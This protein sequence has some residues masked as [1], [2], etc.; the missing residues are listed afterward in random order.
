[1]KKNLPVTQVEVPFTKG[2]YIVSKTDLKGCITYANETFI[3]LSGFSR[4]E[5]YGQSHNLVR[6]PDM[7]PAAFADL[8]ATVK[9]GRPW[10]GI[11]K[12]RCKNGDHYW[13]DALVV[14]VRKDGQTLGYMSVRTEPSRAQIQGAE[15][16]YQRLNAGA[17]TLP[18]PGFWRRLSLRGKMAGLTLFVMAAQALTGVA[19]WFG[20]GMGFSADSIVTLVQ[21]LNLAGLIAGGIQIGLQQGIFRAID[22]TNASLDRVAQG[23]LSE[24][25]WH[26]RLDEVGK[27]QDSLLATQAHLKVMLAEIAEAAQRVNANTRELNAEMTSVSRQSESQ[28]ESVGRIAA[29]MEEMSAAVDQVSTDAKQ[30]AEAVGATRSHIDGVGRRMRQGREASRAVVGAVETASA[31]MATLFQSLN[32]IGVVTQAIQEIADQTNLIALN[33]AIEAARAGEAGRG[34]AVVAD[35]VR[36]LA[37]RTRQQTSEIAG[38]VQEIHRVTETAV[39]NIESA[40]N[41]VGYN[42]AAMGETEADLAEVVRDGESIDEM[43]GHIAEATI[44]Q[45]QASQEVTANISEIAAL[46]EENAA[47]IAD[48]ENNVSQLL[49]TATELD[50]L[51]GYFRFRPKA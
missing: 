20:E 11:V 30:T 4:E 16:L 12:N 43:A 26:E 50:R 32:R 31:T 37:E 36:K 5:L 51:I 23:D 17:A 38:T 25:L 39:A 3:T 22:R 10:R 46:I 34:F 18:R 15:A 33:A 44:Q 9:E 45:S 6:H 47:A 14:P 48:A 42:D 35:E 1:M 21:G 7:P 29:S 2:K 24:D 41:Q 28:S 40:G 19:V 49:E 8:W 13:V 27:L